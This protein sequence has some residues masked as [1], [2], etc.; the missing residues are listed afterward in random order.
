M[1]NSLWPPAPSK[2]GTRWGQ[3]QT[4]RNDQPRVPR[5]VSAGLGNERS[6]IGRGCGSAH[7]W[8]F[9]NSGI[10]FWSLCFSCTCHLLLP[11]W[12]KLKS[13]KCN[14]YS[15]E[16]SSTFLTLPLKEHQR[17]AWKVRTESKAGPFPPAR[18][19]LHSE[20][21]RPVSLHLQH[22]AFQGAP[23]ENTLQADFWHVNLADKII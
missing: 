6:V 14:I 5:P 15:T 7:I 13:L 8:D 4:V 12:G 11:Y 23:E 10:K 3:E 18:L 19:T 1:K 16:A 21:N 22:S 20:G 17:W 9:L 2:A